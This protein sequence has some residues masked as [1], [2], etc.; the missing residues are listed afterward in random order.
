[1]YTYDSDGN[2]IDDYGN[3]IHD[4]WVHEGLK[5]EEYYAMKAVDRAYTEELQEETDE[6][7]KKC[8]VSNITKDKKYDLVSKIGFNNFKPFGEKVQSFS[9]KPLTLIYGPN[10]IGKSSFIHMSAYMRY[11]FETQSFDFANTDMFGDNINLGGFDK[12]I[13]LKWSLNLMI[14]VK[15][16][17][18]I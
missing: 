9:K 2:M 17:L 7:Y 3:T 11:I 10:S 4:P 16:L 1:M 6:A 8:L 18:N 12:F 13:H 5:E 14:V 15:Q